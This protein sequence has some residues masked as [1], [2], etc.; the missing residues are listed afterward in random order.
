MSSRHLA[1]TCAAGL[2]VVLLAGCGTSTPATTSTAI[3]T[4]IPSVTPATVPQL[5]SIMLRATDLP[6]GWEAAPYKADPNAAAIDATMS[7]CVGVRNTDGDKVAAAHSGTF[8]LG[9]ARVSSSVASYR[10]Q[11]DLDVDTA[12]LHSPKL[13]LCFQRQLK[14]QIATSL[15]AGET[16][17]SA[18]L[19]I[20]PGSAG[21]PSNVLGA[22]TGK[23]TVGANGQR[24]TFYVSIAFIIGPLIEAEVDSFNVGT[25]VPSAVLRSLAA[26]VATR[27]ATL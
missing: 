20:T 19:H 10:S 22:G 9:D 14:R 12:I 4:P 27:A 6:V 11:S 25:P 2:G 1:L 7:K 8:T 15:P 26:F 5:N 3:D 21:G 24:V 16:I 13:S 23:V 18:S 17:E